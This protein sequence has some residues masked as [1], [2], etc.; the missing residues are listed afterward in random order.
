[1]DRTEAAALL[2]AC[3]QAYRTR[4]HDELREQLLAPVAEEV[5][6]P[7]GKRYQLLVQAGWMDSPGGA[8]RVVGGIDDRGWQEFA[9]ITES[10]IVPPNGTAPSDEG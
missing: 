6:G 4:S 3:L 5:V 1:M 2:H 9:P 8:L 10:F 7:S